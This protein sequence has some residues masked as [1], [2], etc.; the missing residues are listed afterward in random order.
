MIGHIVK[1]EFRE[2]LIWERRSRFLFG[3]GK[4]RGIL[5]NLIE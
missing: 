3:K 4:F 5:H 2:V 1:E